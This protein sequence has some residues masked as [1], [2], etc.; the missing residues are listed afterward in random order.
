MTLLTLTRGLGRVGLDRFRRRV[1]SAFVG[2]PIDLAP[3]ERSGSIPMDALAL[4]MLAASLNYKSDSIFRLR[5]QLLDQRRSL[6]EAIQ[7]LDSTRVQN[8]ALVAENRQLANQLLEASGV[9]PATWT[10][11]GTDD[12][13]PQVTQ[14]LLVDPLAAAEAKLRALEQP[15]SAAGV[16][17]CGTCHS[18]DPADRPDVQQTDEGGTHYVSC[19]DRFHL[20][21]LFAQHGYVRSS[22]DQWVHESNRDRDCGRMSERE[23]LQVLRAELGD[24]IDPIESEADNDHDH[25]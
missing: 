10:G 21:A 7:A 8:T 6:R 5:G 17:G 12:G 9:E 25:G 23:V 11:D 20:P 2:L 18:T 16:V 4:G 15:Q 1:G 19:P 22:F 13:V 24:L 3:L 14:G